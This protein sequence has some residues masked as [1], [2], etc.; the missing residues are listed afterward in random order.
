MEANNVRVF[1]PLQQHHLIINH[2]LVSPDILLEYD[3]DCVSFSIALSLAH[4]AICAGAQCPPETVLCPARL[5]EHE[6]RAF[7]SDRLLV[8]TVWLAL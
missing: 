5:S 1:H 3:L 8:I 2:L 4:N 6:G 7:G